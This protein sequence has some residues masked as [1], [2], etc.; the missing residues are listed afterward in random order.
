MAL[1]ISTNHPFLVQ[2]IPQ[3]ALPDNVDV[4]MHK[5]LDA[6]SK[7]ELSI[8]SIFP[9][10]QLLKDCN[11]NK[12]FPVKRKRFR[13]RTSSAYWNSPLLTHKQELAI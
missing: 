11:L 2:D 3:W 1:C 6:L 10:R 5:Q 13:Q 7:H 9:P 4:A 8:S 12:I